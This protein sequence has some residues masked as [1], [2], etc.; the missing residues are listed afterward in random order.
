MALLARSVLLTVL[1]LGTAAASSPAQR[2][3]PMRSPECAAAMKTL[4]AAEQAAGGQRLDAEGTRRLRA[5]QRQAA[6]ACLGEERTSPPRTGA[7]L[8][9]PISV[10][11]VGAG[12]GVG[13]APLRLPAPA[14]VPVPIPAPAVDAAR[15]WITSCDAT[16]CWGS[17]GFRYQRQ[18][19]TL[20]I[21]PRG[22]CTM[23]GQSLYCP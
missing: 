2:S 14:S 22:V 6:K 20:L 19:E 8:Q 15:P 16:G 3:D 4:D 1:T 10:N 17:D 7:R 9:A 23:Q 5:L 12:V 18:G 13:A 21:G 11:G